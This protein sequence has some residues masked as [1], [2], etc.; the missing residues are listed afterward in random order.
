M[1]ITRDYTALIASL[2]CFDF[3]QKKKTEQQ[4][5]DA[6]REP[7]RPN[8]KYLS[9]SSRDSCTKSLTQ[10]SAAHIGLC[11]IE[12]KIEMVNWMGSFTTEIDKERGFKT[13]INNVQETNKMIHHDYSN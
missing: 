8:R 3:D 13:H 12:R 10:E 5:Y 1:Q 11:Y 2:F 4:D 6:N 9:L 7:L